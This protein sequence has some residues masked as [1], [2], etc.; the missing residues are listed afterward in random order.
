M[1]WA[2]RANAATKRGQAALTAAVLAAAAPALAGGGAGKNIAVQ[3]VVRG[4]AQF[5]NSGAITTIRA[6]DR[7]IINYSK[8]NI[9]LDEKVTFIQPSR[10][11]RVLNRINSAEPSKLDGT[12]T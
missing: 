12:L 1:G 5:S 4:S 9:A 11:S 2:N 8:F 3:K 6:A 7:T 10:T